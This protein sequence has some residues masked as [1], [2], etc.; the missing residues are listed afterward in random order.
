[1]KYLHLSLQYERAVQHPM[2]RFLTDSATLERSWLITWNL[3]GE[4]DVIYTLFYLIGDRERYKQHIAGAEGTVDY[5]ITPVDD[6][7]FYAYVRE[8]EKAIFKRFRTA[9]QQPSVVV[10]PPLAYRPNGRVDFDVVGEPDDLAGILDRLPDEITAEV[11][12]VGEYD[13]RPGVPA[14]D[15]TGRQREA[16]RAAVEVGFYEYPRTGSVA[17]VA[18]ILDCATSTA[19]THLQKAEARLIRHCIGNRRPR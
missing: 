19:S 11:S 1:M 3:L 7:S 16:L 5:N 14:V 8:R 10:V 2:Q 18:E 4:G 15:L 6:S 12:E 17:D 9:F 13:A